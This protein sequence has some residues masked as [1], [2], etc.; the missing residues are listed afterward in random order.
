MATILQHRRGNTAQTVVFTGASG[1]LFINTDNN[2]V[3]VQDGANAGGWAMATAY[4]YTPNSLILANATGVIQNTSPVSLIT[5][6]NTLL[7]SSNVIISGN[8]TVLGT[9]ITVNQETINTNEV[10]AGQLTAN[11]GIA[12]VNVSSGALI[13][14]G[15][16][17]ISGNVYTSAV[18]ANTVNAITLNATTGMTINNVPVITQTQAILYSIILG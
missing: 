2:Q 17:G 1:E 15:G 3:V 10:V 4:G 9:S 5:A 13:V 18:I 16:A 12:S 6:N 14:Q 8:L 11:S 7:A